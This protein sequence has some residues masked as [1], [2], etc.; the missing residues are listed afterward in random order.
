MAGNKAGRQRLAALSEGSP[1]TRTCGKQGWRGGAAGPGGVHAS[2]SAWAPCCCS[3]GGPEAPALATLP[4][5][6]P[7]T[8]ASQCCPHGLCPQPCPQH[9]LWVLGTGGLLLSPACHVPV[10]LG[11]NL[12]SP[13]SSRVGPHCTQ[14]V[15]GWEKPGL[16]SE[17]T[18]PCTHS[19][20]Q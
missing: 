20:L 7:W 2:S 16:P 4:V 5:S 1:S 12:T 9:P 14:E 15:P 18:H 13:L 3:P 19:P 17:P 6:R 11:E 8:L 10:W